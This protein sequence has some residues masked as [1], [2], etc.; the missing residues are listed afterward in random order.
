MCFVVTFLIENSVWSVAIIRLSDAR[1][2]NGE[3]GKGH[4]T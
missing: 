4:T 2:L 1:G 3:Q